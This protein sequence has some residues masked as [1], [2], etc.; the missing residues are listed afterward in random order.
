MEGKGWDAY[1]QAQDRK[2]KSPRIGAQ[3]YDHVKI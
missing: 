2:A 1:Q 3:T